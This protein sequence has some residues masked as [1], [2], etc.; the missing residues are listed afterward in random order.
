ME[1]DTQEQNR[2]YRVPAD[3]VALIWCVIALMYRSAVRFLFSDSTALHNVAFP[4][5]VKIQIGLSPIRSNW[6]A[7]TVD[8]DIAGLPLYFVS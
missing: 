1:I 4:T 8:T 7:C 6:L 2:R 5:D 3:R